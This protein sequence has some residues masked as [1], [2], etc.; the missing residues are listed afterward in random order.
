M[1]PEH[2]QV[3]QHLDR[4]PSAS[5]QRPLDRSH[6]LVDMGLEHCPGFGAE[7][8]DAAELAVGGRLRDGDGERRV[9]Q[10]A[11]G[12]GCEVTLGGQSVEGWG[13][14]GIVADRAEHA[15]QPGLGAGLRHSGQ[16]R[17]RPH[18][19]IDHSGE[20]AAQGFQGRELG[21]EI[22]R[23]VIHAALE[24]HPDAAEDLR[25]LSEHQRL[26]ERLREMGM[27][28]HEARHQQRARQRHGCEGRVRGHQGGRLGHG[29]EPAVLHQ[30][31][32]AGGR[33]VR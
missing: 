28:V 13:S 5:D 2:A 12:P 19:G 10:S 29:G 9:D 25:G 26:A 15:A 4:P 11:L 22:D 30:D 8:S 33:A 31:A 18:P 20:P 3:A 7:S 16:P 24:R 21:G 27:C 32:D 14:A 1:W 17:G 6:V 23:F